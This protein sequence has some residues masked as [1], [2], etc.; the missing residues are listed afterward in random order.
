[1]STDQSSLAKYQ[2]TLEELRAVT[3]TLQQHKGRLLEIEKTLKSLEQT[4]SQ[5]VYKAMGN[6]FIQ[7]PKE[8]VIKELNSEKELLQLRI[9]EFSKREKLLRERLT[10]LGRQLRSPAG[11][12]G[13]G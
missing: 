1:M 2:Q 8:E 10:S 5:Y 3:L 13:A 4:Q 6:L 9:E 11:P 12:G 7:T